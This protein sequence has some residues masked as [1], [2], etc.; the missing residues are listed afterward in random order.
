MGQDPGRACS[1]G[2]VKG[3]EMIAQLG[4]GK[5]QESPLPEGTW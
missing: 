1:E 2:E 4:P 5:S 3:Q